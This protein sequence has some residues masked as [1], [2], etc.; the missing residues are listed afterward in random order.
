ME[1]KPQSIFDRLDSIEATQSVT[2]SQ[3]EEIIGLLKNLSNKKHEDQ[4]VEIKPQSQVSEKQLLINFIRSSKKEY[5]WFGT[6]NDFEKSKAILCILCIALIVVG[7]ISTILTSIAFKTYSTFTLFENIWLILVCI[8]LSH[9][10]NVK[11]RMVDTDLKTHSNTVYIQD[12]DGTWRNT[13][14]ERKKYRFFRRIS[15]IAV[16]CNIIVI[17]VQSKG[18]IAISATIFELIFAGLTIGVFIAYSNLFCM[19]DNFILFTGRNEA[20]TANVTLLF[21]VMSKKLA[22]YDEYN[23]NIKKIL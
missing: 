18:A 11:K 20:N 7:I 21:D 15:Y 13:N 2:Q 16:I 19:Y 10:L 9:S 14:K 1:N 22:P 3:N 8:M 17:W 4:T 12:S 6:I 5:I 23:E